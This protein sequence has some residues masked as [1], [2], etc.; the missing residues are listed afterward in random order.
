[1]ERRRYSGRM[2]KLIVSL[3]AGAVL[4]MGTLPADAA[5][6]PSTMAITTFA[7]L[8]RT[9]NPKI[10]DWQ[11]RE[12]A[13]HLLLSA[14]HW[15]L[16]ATM[17]VALM[18]VESRW[19]TQAVSRAGAVGLGQL[20]PM[21]AANLHV[22]PRDP[23]QN[24][25]GSARY[26]GGLMERFHRRRSL[27]IAAYNAGPHAVTQYGGIPP[28]AETQ[29]YVVRVLRAWKHLKKTVRMPYASELESG[30]ARDNDVG[31]W[32]QH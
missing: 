11:S 1:M 6:P 27:A 22:N 18:T 32:S 21:T 5:Q 20:M 24:I 3:I 19:R 26:L 15:R 12:F 14:S 4:C 17:L 30:L 25:S 8:L 10:S 2:R 9:I 29:H 23:I 13:R 28:Y 7:T 31:Y 16:D